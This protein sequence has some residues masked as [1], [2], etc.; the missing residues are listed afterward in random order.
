MDQVNSGL[1]SVLVVSFMISCGGSD[2]TAS[3]AMGGTSAVGGATPQCKFNRGVH[4][5]VVHF[6]S[7]RRFDGNVFPRYD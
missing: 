4:L 3:T 1:I 5:P 2:T 7:S 6:D